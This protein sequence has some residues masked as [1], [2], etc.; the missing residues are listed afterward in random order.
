MGII[1]V[2]GYHLLHGHARVNIPPSFA[3][4]GSSST[5]LALAWRFFKFLDHVVWNI[6]SS[7]ATLAPIEAVSIFLAEHL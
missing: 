4:R 7:T 5:G 1:I 3:L 2:E 6:S